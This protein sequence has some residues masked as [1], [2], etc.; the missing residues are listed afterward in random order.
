MNCWN[1]SKPIDVPDNYCR[2]CGSGQGVFVPW[3]LK[4]L[5]IV[6]MTLFALGP[7]NLGNIWKT[8]LWN[9]KV[10]IGATVA[11]LVYTAWLGLMVERVV[12]DAMSLVGG[13]MTQFTQMQGQIQQAS[14]LLNVLKGP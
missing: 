10:K 12:E 6:L 4:P 1:C 8:P 3:Y 5:G 2:Y 13:Q 11:T 7:F 9:R 14:S